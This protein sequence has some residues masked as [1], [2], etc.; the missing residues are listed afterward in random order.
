MNTEFE[1]QPLDWFVFAAVLLGTFGVVIFGNIRQRKLAD[2]GE[3]AGFLDLLLMGRRLTLPLFT[4]TLVATWYGGIIGV[5]EYA[6]SYGLYSWVTQGGFWY[7]AYL[8]FAFFLVGRIRKTEAVT[9]PD[10]L[11]KEFGPTAGKWGA[12]MNLFNVLPVAYLASLAVFLKQI[13]GERADLEWMLLGLAV[14]IAYSVIGGFRSV[15]FSDLVQFG[16]MCSAVLLVIVFS[17]TTYGGIGWLKASSEIPASHWKPF[18]EG[19]PFN[20]TLVWGLVAAGTLV[21]PNF[22]HRC[23]AAKDV[24]TARRGILCATL[25][26]VAFDFCTTFGAFYARAVLPEVPPREAYL[27]YGVHVLPAGLRGWFLAGFLATILS[28]LDSYL[29][30]SGT[31]VSYDLVPARFKGSRMLHHAGT[32]LVGLVAIGIAWW[33]DREEGKLADIWKLLGGFST[34]TLLFPLLMGLSLR[35]KIPG[36]V[37]V[38]SSATGAL[39]MAVFYL[40]KLKFSHPLLELDAFY[41]GLLGTTVAWTLSRLFIRPVPVENRN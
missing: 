37:F 1:F 11:S 10:M 2:R 27:T 38:I 24:K 39:F 19:V 6:H 25:I 35:Q 17:M 8:I 41:P 22:Y 18:G 12:V 20:L 4:G 34:A 26:W 3:E 21:D 5:T 14:V 23:L 32:V 36:A 40:L 30:L 13:F 15:V 31:I 16:V 9:M 28:T 29:F 7:G 33:I